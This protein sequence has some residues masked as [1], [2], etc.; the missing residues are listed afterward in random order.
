METRMMS[1][2]SWHKYYHQQDSPYERDA[3][4]AVLDLPF[5]QETLGF[6]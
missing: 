1:V 6:P 4:E 2:R 5:S 3:E